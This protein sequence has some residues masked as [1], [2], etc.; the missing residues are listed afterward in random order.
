[1]LQAAAAP[2][3]PDVLLTPFSLRRRR[4]S[5]SISVPAHTHAEGMLVLVHEGLVMVQSGQRVLTVAAKDGTGCGAVRRGTQL[6]GGGLVR[7]QRAFRVVL[8]VWPGRN[9]RQAER[10]PQ[11]L[12]IRIG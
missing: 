5:K 7:M 8:G 12:A 3:L 4:E 2:S 10:Q 9:R 6:C 11:A 1:M